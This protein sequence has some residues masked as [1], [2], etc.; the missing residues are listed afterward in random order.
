[1]TLALYKSCTYLLTYLL[2]TQPL[3]AHRP[4]ADDNLAAQGHDLINDWSLPSAHY[5]F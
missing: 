4:A 5:I 2:N 3:P 1:M